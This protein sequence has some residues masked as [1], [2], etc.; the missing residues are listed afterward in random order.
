MDANEFQE[1]DDFWL[2]VLMQSFHDGVEGL[3]I[4]DDIFLALGIGAVSIVRANLPPFYH[5]L[6]GYSLHPGYQVTTH[7]FPGPN[8]GWSILRMSGQHKVG[9]SGEDGYRHVGDQ[10]RG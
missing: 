9:N 8:V 6:L 4:H 2:V 7:H 1:Q 10:G 3:G 5:R